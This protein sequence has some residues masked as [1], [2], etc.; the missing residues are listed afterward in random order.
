MSTQDF[1]NC[2]AGTFYGFTRTEYNPGDTLNLQWGAI[3]DG[4]TPLN[5]TLGRAGGTIIDEI[6]VGAQFTETSALYQLVV[7]ETANCTLEQ[8]SWAIP[9]D[10]N[11]TNPEYQIGLFN[12]S[13]LL[14]ADG[15]A[16]F[17]WQSW[18]P[19]FYVREVNSSTVTSTTVTANATGTATTASLT[20][21]AQATSSSS[22]SASLG[23]HSSSS[24]TVAIGVGVGVGV[25]GLAGICFGALY[26]LRRRR[27][28]HIPS[29]S[30][31][32]DDTTEL[33]PYELAAPTKPPTTGAPRTYELAA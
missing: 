15:N 14:G 3:D 21:S 29:Q 13:V 8:Y 27:K 1:E 25:A 5:I 33:P 6:V 20:S 18:S 23:T 24:N 26:F 30:S 2:V 17:G 11:T 16:F 10:F 28:T 32:D 19:D 7:N 22:P 31:G 9:G 4:A 12:A